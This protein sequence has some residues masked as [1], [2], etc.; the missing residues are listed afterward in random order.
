[1]VKLTFLQVIA[2]YD[3]GLDS[4]Q[5]RDLKV[6]EYTS[7]V[8]FSLSTCAVGC[9]LIIREGLPGLLRNKEAQSFILREQGMQS[10]H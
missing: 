6:P 10:R 8:C 1:M 2:G 3:E 9:R 5:P 4:R 7:L